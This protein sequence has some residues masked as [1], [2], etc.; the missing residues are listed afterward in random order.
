MFNIF[1]KNKK[2]EFSLEHLEEHTVPYACHYDNQSLLTKNGELMQVIK[3]E[4]YSKEMMNS[5]DD[6]DL[7]NII[8]RAIIENINDHKVAIWFHTI[9]RKRNLD[10]INYF[11][12][13]FA[14]DTHD[15]WAD[16][17]HW[18]DK[19][20]N[21]LYIT[22]LY[23]GGGSD[24]QNFALSFS[25]QL[26]KHYHLNKLTYSAQ[27]LDE[28]I[29]KMLDIL[30]PF[31]G[32]R[33][34]V[35]HDSHGAH[36]EILEFLSKITCLHS[37]R[38]AI[39]I[40]SIDNIFNRSQVAFGGNAMEILDERKKHYAAI[41][42]IKEYH[43]FAAKALDKFLRIASE[44]VISQTLTFTSASEAKKP[45]EY[46]NYILGVSKDEELK[47]QCGLTDIM[48]SD[49]GKQNDYG[50]QQMSFMILGD[51]LEEL[52]RAAGSAVEELGNLGII[53]IREDLNIE[54]C[55]WS[56][57]P[58]NFNFFRRPSYI[59]TKKS[60][61]FASLNNNPSGKTENLWGSAVTLFR[62]RDGGPHFFNFHIEK[63]GHTIIAGDTKSSKKTLLNFLLSESSKYSPH[64][65]YIDQY[66]TSRVLVKALEGRHEIINLE[67]EEL[68][69]SFNPF[70]IADS[71]ENHAF[72]K[73]WMLLLIFPNGNHTEQQKEIISAGLDKF[74]TK[75]PV[76]NRQIS[77][78]VELFEDETIRNNL[79]LWCRPNKL[80]KLFDNM[81]DEFES[82]PKIIGFNIKALSEDP[83]AL[84]ALVFYCLYYYANLKNSPPAIIVLD[85]ANQ[86]LQ[87]KVFSNTLPNLLDKFTA[88]NAI[89][90]FMWN[91]KNLL[92]ENIQN[93]N[94]KISTHLLTIHIN[95]KIYQD[96][97]KL[98]AEEISD[99]NKMKTINRHFMIKQ[100]STRTIV[101]L[102]LDGLD[103]A[104]KALAGQEDALDAMEKAIKEHG[105]NPNIW[106]V[107]FYKNLFPN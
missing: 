5:S 77:M 107:P 79:L 51:T 85:D 87:D 17:N 91:T 59:N 13:T 104:I 4:G 65:L 47:N 80:G 55:F 78:L 105:E 70:H 8:R 94:D 42:T 73:E 52:E 88:N 31:G 26:L 3:I 75:M 36:S 48:E 100:K 28:I 54:L 45:C 35:A 46:L 89:A 58:G 30:R 10:S 101:E 27:A 41:F 34:E 63:N 98:T 18:R 68:D 43:E 11:S 53:V 15:S 67:K 81:A 32:K 66:D 99:L 40:Q 23:E 7:R 92:N 95:Y 20:V 90:I 6:V 49:F 14:K 102:N 39:P 9:R 19:F 25:P 29:L 44:Y 84:K 12:S 62:R 82:S 37:K 57:L 103:Y 1:K 61:S 56:Q 93:I 71:P 72:L 74:F 83:N 97:F 33:L 22:I 106:I 69:F 96:A 86:L 50:T 76:G 16:K 2:S 60:A 21:E 24:R 38:V 64:I